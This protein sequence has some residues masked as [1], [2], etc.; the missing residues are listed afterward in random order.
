[1]KLGLGTAQFGFNYGISNHDGQTSE[2]EAKRVLAV[3][4][5]NGI[6]VIDTA[7]LYGNSEEVVGKVLPKDHS[8]NLVTK[9]VRI[10]KNRI[11][12]HD[13]E[14]IA[15][16]FEKSLEN[17]R[18]N[19]VYG[20]MI[21]NAND[22]LA[23]DGFLL[24]E[25][26]L[27][28]KSMGR[29]KKIGVSVYS[30]HQI[31]KILTKYSIDIVQLPLNI[32]DQ[33]LLRSNLLSKLKNSGIEIHIRSVFLQ[34]LLLMNPETLTPYFDSVRQHLFRYHAFLRENCITPL[35]AA[36]G[37]VCGLDHVDAVICGVN[38]HAQLDEICSSCKPLP[39][40][41]FSEFAVSDTSILDPSNWRIS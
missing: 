17:L 10:N 8:F 26:L 33:R 39:Q 38:N 5:K 11:K 1:M 32:L 4:L 37:F 7:A 6:R 31:D 16:A 29:V 14:L 9:T 2:G 28:L 35:E 41:I 30:A 22:L 34:G 13:A 15:Q 23:T 27:R 40:S 20:L 3:A 24:Y 25:T 18:C 12:T 36:L 21:H 19:S